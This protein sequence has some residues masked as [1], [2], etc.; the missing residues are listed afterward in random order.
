M[1]LGPTAIR[2]LDYKHSTGTEKVQLCLNIAHFY[3]RFGQESE[4]RAS[5]KLDV[6]LHLSRVPIHLQIF[7]RCCDSALQQLVRGPS[8]TDHA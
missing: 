4:F 5:S 2:Q 1:Q 7:V 3:K 8:Q 6:R